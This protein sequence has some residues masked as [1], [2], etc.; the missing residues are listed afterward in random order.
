MRQLVILTTVTGLAGNDQIIRA[1]GTSA[2]QWNDMIDRRG[3]GCI[4]QLLS[5]IITAVALL[6]YL[7]SHVGRCVTATRAHFQSA[8]SLIFNACLYSTVFSTSIPSAI[9]QKPRTIALYIL[10]VDSLA[11]FCLT[12]QFSLFALPLAHILT[13]FNFTEPTEFDILPMRIFLANLILPLFVRGNALFMG[14]TILLII[15]ALLFTVFLIVLS[16]LLTVSVI[17]DLALSLHAN[18]AAWTETIF[19]L[20]LSGEK[21]RGGRKKLVTLCA[22]LLRGIILWYH[23]HTVRLPFLSSRLGSVSSTRSGSTFLP[24]HYIIHR[25]VEQLQGVYA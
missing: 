24:L 16:V 18:L 21:F 23:V 10:T 25:P 15:S 6:L 22:S 7:I 5:T 19:R 4:A 14:F 9:L 13:F 17:V 3:A 2:R 1:V 11:M 12:A 20:S 8:A